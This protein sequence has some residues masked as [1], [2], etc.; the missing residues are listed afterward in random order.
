M[1]SRATSYDGGSAGP[2]AAAAAEAAA[3]AAEAAAAAAA[4]PPGASDAAAAAAAADAAA[5]PASAGSCSAG[6]PC[7]SGSAGCVLG[8]RGKEKGNWERGKRAWSRGP[9]G[10]WQG[11]RHAGILGG[12]SPGAPAPDSREA[13]GARAATSSIVQPPPPGRLAT[14]SA[15]IPSL[16]R[17]LIVT[18]SFPLLSSARRIRS[19]VSPGLCACFASPRL[20]SSLHPRGC[21]NTRQARDHGGH[22]VQRTALCSACGAAAAPVLVC[23]SG[24]P[25]LK[26]GLNRQWEAIPRAQRSTECSCAPKVATRT[27]SPLSPPLPPGC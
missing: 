5:A 25:L 13:Q 22:P 17:F 10:A 27:P 2:G 24:R 14:C 11:H 16:F 3:A 4:A 15:S 9:P 1:M 23:R 21:A 8:G 20:A 6:K 18:R 19:E 12:S 7:G 26:E